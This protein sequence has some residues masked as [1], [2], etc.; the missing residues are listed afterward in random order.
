[1]FQDFGDM[2]QS[3]LQ[4]DSNS[5]NY[6]TPGKE[7]KGTRATRATQATSPVQSSEETK[8]LATVSLS[9]YWFVLVAFVINGFYF[10]SQNI[11]MRR[12]RMVSEALWTPAP[13]FVLSPSNINL[14][15][16]S[17]FGKPKHL[18]GTITSP[19]PVR[20]HPYDESSWFGTPNQ[21]KEASIL[22]QRYLSQ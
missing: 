16:S 6:T 17:C 22:A 3:A 12:C 2:L 19:L 10:S 21:L 4:K 20:I 11:A 5:T 18:S 9:I 13:W 15:E 14:Q 7:G 1:M 8:E